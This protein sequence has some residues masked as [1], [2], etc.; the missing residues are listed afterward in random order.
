M[1][2]IVKNG[3]GKIHLRTYTGGI[4]YHSVH[5][6]V[7]WKSWVNGNYGLYPG[8]RLRFAAF[9]IHSTVTYAVLRPALSTTTSKLTT[10]RAKRHALFGGGHALAI[11]V[12]GFNPL[13]PCLRCREETVKQCIGD[14]AWIVNDEMV[15]CSRYAWMLWRVSV[16]LDI[17]AFGNLQLPS[18]QLTNCGINPSSAASCSKFT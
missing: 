12:V 9:A 4:L 18:L 10:L 5:T 16:A 14:Y 1:D 11:R 3:C 17:Y 7:G 2:C 8:W 13:P 6:V 15:C